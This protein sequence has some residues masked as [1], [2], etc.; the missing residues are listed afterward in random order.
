MMNEPGTAVPEEYAL[1][2]KLFS[3]LVDSISKGD[4]EIATPS[5][6]EYVEEFKKLFVAYS[7]A[8]PDTRPAAVSEEELE[9]VYMEKEREFFEENMAAYLEQYPRGAPPVDQAKLDAIFSKEQYEIFRQKFWKQ[10]SDVI[11]GDDKPFEPPLIVQDMLAE[12]ETLEHKTYPGAG[13]EFPYSF[14]ILNQFFP[15]GTEMPKGGPIM[16]AVICV[17]PQLKKAAE[18]VAAAKTK[19]EKGEVL[20]FLTPNEKSALNSARSVAAQAEKVGAPVVVCGGSLPGLET[21]Q[22]TDADVKEALQAMDI[23][24]EGNSRLNYFI[25]AYRANNFSFY[26]DYAVHRASEPLAGPRQIIVTK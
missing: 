14:S 19:R 2:K 13:A 24:E 26:G 10:T 1:S 11:S 23:D 4:E 18:M 6:E 20:H 12:P 9:F 25:Q 15:Q 21:V 17:T 7:E 3:N 16:G 8:Y 22:A 5:P